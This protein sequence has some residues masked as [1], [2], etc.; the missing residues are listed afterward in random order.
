MRYTDR[1]VDL[2]G[3]DKGSLSNGITAFFRGGIESLRQSCGRSLQTRVLN[4][5]R[6]SGKPFESYRLRTCVH[7]YEIYDKLENDFAEL[8][9][10]ADS[11]KLVNKEL[12]KTP[13][14]GKQPRSYWINEISY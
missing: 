10:L 2:L 6:I 11:L 3:S 4:G 8:N 9:K 12:V 5:D 7:G 13:F 14:S 1:L